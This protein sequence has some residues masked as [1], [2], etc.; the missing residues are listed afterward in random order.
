MAEDREIYF[1]ENTLNNLLS[2]LKATERGL[3]TNLNY[4]LCYK[5]GISDFHICAQ[6]KY[7]DTSESEWVYPDNEFGKINMN[8][9]LIFNNALDGLQDQFLVVPIP[10]SEDG[11]LALDESFTAISLVGCLNELMN[12]IGSYWTKDGNSLYPTDLNNIVGIGVIP[13][14]QVDI[15]KNQDAPTIVKIKNINDH[16]TAYVGFLAESKNNNF[17]ALYVCPPLYSEPYNNKGILYSGENSGMIIEQAEEFPIDFYTNSTLRMQIAENGNIGIGV[18]PTEKVSIQK[19]QNAATRLQI[20]NTTDGVN[21][22]SSLSAVSAGGNNVNIS[23][24]SPTYSLTRY[25]DKGLFYSGGNSGMIIEQSGN[26][27]IDIWTNSLKRISISGVGAV[28]LYAYSEGIPYL[29]GTL[30]KTDATLFHYDEVYSKFTCGGGG[31]TIYPS[32]TTHKIDSNTDTIEFNSSK[33]V[34]INPDLNVVSNIGIGVETHNASSVR[35]LA[36][37]NGTPPAVSTVNQISMWVSSGELW[38]I[39]SAGNSS[40]LSPHNEKNEWIFKCENKRIGKK[41]KIDVERFFKWFDKEYDTNFVR[42]D[43]C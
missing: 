13:T 3:I 28:D 21:A 6:Q 35:Y 27:P 34:R 38:V 42:E 17:I 23:A 39:D 29:R 14:E 32:T 11:I 43:Q 22:Y 40:Q 2:L 41:I 9:S 36:I 19:N 18:I 7:Y 4:N 8:D 5:D 10:I 37:T 30:L 12:T 15:L 20:L 1:Y 26:F 31:L 25:Q 16:I 24:V 33:R